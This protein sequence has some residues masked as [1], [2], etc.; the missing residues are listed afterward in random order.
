[1]KIKLLVVAATLFASC[2]DQSKT[3]QF[4]ALPYED[5]TP[6]LIIEHELETCNER[7][8][9]YQML[10][11]KTLSGDVESM[12]KLSV[13]KAMIEKELNELKK[14][15]ALFDAKQT[16]KFSKTHEKFLVVDCR[17]K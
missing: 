14:L 15:S 12:K 16:E 1:M 10:I 8:T 9:K 17:V 3:K 2:T 11:D 4:D 13:T 6:S 7:I 5:Q